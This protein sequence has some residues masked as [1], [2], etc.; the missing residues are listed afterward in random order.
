[1]KWIKYYTVIVVLFTIIIL[2][3]NLYSKLYFIRNKIK[4]LL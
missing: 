4:Y 1:M 2:E 3:I